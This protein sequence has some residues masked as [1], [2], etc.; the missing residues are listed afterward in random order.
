MKMRKP[1]KIN[2]KL[3]D[4]VDDVKGMSDDMMEAVTVAFEA[5]EKRNYDEIK[6][7]LQEIQ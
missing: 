5:N 7:Y 2:R 1:K 4:R 6:I 3:R